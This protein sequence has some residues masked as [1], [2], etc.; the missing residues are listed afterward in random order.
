MMKRI[1][2]LR[3]ISRKLMLLITIIILVTVVIIGSTSYVVAKNQLLESGQRELQS[4][5]KG[6]YTS[7]E[8]IN[9]EVEIGKITLEE[10]KEQARIILNG[11]V[12]ENGEYDYQKSHFTYKENGYI[13]AFDEDLVLQLHPSKVELLSMI[14]TEVIEKRSLQAASPKMNQIAM[15]FIL[16]NSQMVLLKIKQPIQNILSLGVGLLELLFFKMN[17]MKD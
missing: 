13:L 4:I 5:V 15:S 1:L 8:L 16:I 6:A 7:L 17:F 2:Q 10:G 9:E 14:S 12:N 11:P 3:S